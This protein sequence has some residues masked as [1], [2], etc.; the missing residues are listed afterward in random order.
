MIAYLDGVIAEVRAGSLVVQTGGFGLEVWAPKPTLMV[1]KV[2]AAL[3]L[4]TYFLVKEDL[5]ALY[6]FHDRDLY[7]LFTY[8][9]GVSGVG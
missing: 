8:L 4:H 1:A 7:T 3:R 9:I 6:G 2:G 5:M